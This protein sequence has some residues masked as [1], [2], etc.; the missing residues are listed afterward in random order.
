MSVSETLAR[1]LIGVVPAGLWADPGVG[2]SWQPARD[3][4]KFVP[5]GDDDADNA[6]LRELGYVDR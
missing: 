5:V 4:V 1:R 6:M 2:A 3:R